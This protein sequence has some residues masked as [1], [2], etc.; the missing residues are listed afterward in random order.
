MC[1]LIT[2][3]LITWLCV[4][5]NG[6]LVRHSSRRAEEAR[7]HSKHLCGHVFQFIYR[8]IFTENIIT[9]FSSHYCLQHASCWFCN[10]IRSEINNHHSNFLQYKQAVGETETPLI[11]YKPFFTDSCCCLTGQSLS[12]AYRASTFIL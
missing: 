6:N 12:F 4:T 5:L 10:G 7:F 9:N 8:W 11:R 3:H 2:D 1:T